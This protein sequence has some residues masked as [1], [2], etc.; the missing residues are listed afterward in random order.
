M[1]V[2]TTFKSKEL[3]PMAVLLS[4]FY[5]QGLPC[6]TYFQVMDC[7]E[8]STIILGKP[9]IV[10]H[11]CQLNFAKGCILFSLAHKTINLPMG[12]NTP[13][14]TPQPQPKPIVKPIEP[15]HQE[16]KG[17]S[18]TKALHKPNPSKQPQVHKLPKRS[19][20]HKTT[21]RVHQRWV[22]KTLL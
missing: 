22:P 2:S 13:S 3:P 12:N 10:Q 8:D 14:H 16:P 18:K 20:V 19:Q 7:R 6:K 5:I 17:L 15:L 1:S 9:W 21:T 11:Q 4:L